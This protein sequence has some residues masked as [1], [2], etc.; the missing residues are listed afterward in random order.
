MC[1]INQSIRAQDCQVCHV[2][3]QHA[4]SSETAELQERD[5]GIVLVIE[6]SG[7]G[8]GMDLAKDHT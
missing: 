1:L 8:L 6:G 7:V 5:L 4:C 3:L 2:C